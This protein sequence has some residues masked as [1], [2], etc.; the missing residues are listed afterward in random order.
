MKNKK[1]VSLLFNAIFCTSIAVMSSGC[2]NKSTTN[3]ET[4]IYS[5][6]DAYKNYQNFI[7]KIPDDEKLAFMYLAPEAFHE[8]NKYS[9]LLTN[10]KIVN[11]G[12]N[13]YLSKINTPYS[14]DLTNEKLDFS[15]LHSDMAASKKYAIVKEYVIQKFCYKYMKS[16]AATVNESEKKLEQNYYLAS[17]EFF[18]TEKLHS[19]ID[20]AIDHLP[21]KISD[22]E[23][24]QKKEVRE[25][26]ENIEIVNQGGSFGI[27]ITNRTDCRIKGLDVAFPYG[28]KRLSISQQVGP[29]IQDELYWNL[30]YSRNHKY[31]VD[32]LQLNCNGKEIWSTIKGISDDFDSSNNNNNEAYKMPGY[33]EFAEGILKGANTNIPNVDANLLSNKTKIALRKLSVIHLGKE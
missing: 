28:L 30:T 29:G 20:D 1:L 27:V 5:L 7:D 21:P 25:T 10:Q 33:K 31:R 26:I 19:I 9:E 32:S 15:V 3:N 24:K 17:P 12:L 6:S 23:L 4:R 16:L 22:K 13:T 8:A 14:N 18:S 11:S 2:D